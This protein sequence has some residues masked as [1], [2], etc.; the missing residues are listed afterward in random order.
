MVWIFLAE[1][2]ESQKPL[3]DMFVLSPIV[4]TTDTL[5]LCSCQDSEQVNCPS[6]QFGMTCKHCGGT[7]CHKSTLSTEDFPVKTFPLQAAE[8]AWKESEAAYFSRSLGWLARYDR[9]SS[10]WKMCQLSVFGEET[11]LPESWPASGMTVGGRLYPLQMWARTTSESDGGFWPTP[12]GPNNGGTNGKRKLKAMLWP[13]PTVNDAK[14]DAGPSQWERNSFSLNVAAKRWPT[15]RANDAERRGEF[16]VMNPH[17]GL[18]AAA[19]RWPTPQARS[20]PDCVSE[21]KRHTPS[22]DSQVGGQLNPTWVEWLMGYPC[23]W[24]VLE[25]WATQWFRPKRGKRLS[26]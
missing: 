20:A 26:G 14:N 8:R 17:N 7:C 3:K 9:D 4:K 18:P 13:T 23:G 2:E 25:D 15:P 1:S 19:K 21:R 12:C 11:L 22:L 6:L 5:K 10:S 24:T 16:D